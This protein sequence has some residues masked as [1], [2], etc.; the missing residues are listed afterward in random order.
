[1]TKEKPK[2]MTKTFEL[3]SR[4]STQVLMALLYYKESLRK[5]SKSWP[6]TDALIKRFSEQ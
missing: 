2:E 4:E 3:T 6:L 1:M 5:L